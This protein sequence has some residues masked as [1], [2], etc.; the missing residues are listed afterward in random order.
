M[1]GGFRPNK[2]RTS[3]E[4]QTS[5]C[6][7]RSPTPPSSSPLTASARAH[8]A[9]L[10][11]HLLCTTRAPQSALTR[12][13]SLVPRIASLGLEI[14]IRLANNVEPREAKPN[15]AA[16]RRETQSTYHA[17]EHDVAEPAA[18]EPE[19]RLRGRKDKT[20]PFL[21]CGSREPPQFYSQIN[22][23]IFAFDWRLDHTF[24]EVE[25]AGDVTVHLSVTCVACIPSSQHLQRARSTLWDSDTA[26][27]RTCTCYRH[28]LSVLRPHRVG[29]S[30]FRGLRRPA[31]LP[32]LG[33]H[34]THRESFSTQPQEE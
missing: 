19:A 1:G 23:L 4:S 21:S 27:W 10:L 20:R 32:S 9:R 31:V 34:P 7:A 17:P 28:S 11:P 22:V 15:Q 26:I 6:T 25:S 8:L 16:G 3:V 12:A 5:P 13:P 29:L 30:V 33:A 18:H 2:R 14:P 24:L